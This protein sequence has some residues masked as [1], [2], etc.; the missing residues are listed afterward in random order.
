[1]PNPF[2]FS[3]YNLRYHSFDY[4]L[5]ETYGL[6]VMKVPLDAGFTCPNRDGTCGVGGCYFCSQEG[7][8]ELIRDK[9]ASLSQQYLTIKK[10]LNQKWPNA[11]TIPYFQAYTNTYAALAELKQSYEPFLALPEVVGLAIGT[12]PDCLDQ[13]II[14]YLVSLNQKTDIYLELGL[15][16]MFDTTALAFNRGYPLRVFEATIKRLAKTPLKVSVH[17]INGLPDETFDMM[18]DT[19]KYLSQLPLFG[20]KIH[21]LHLLSDSVYGQAYQTE[22]WPL[23]SQTEYIAL[24][25]KQLEL[26]PPELV[27]ER[28]TG[29]GVAA[30]LLAPLWTKKKGIVL[31]EIQKLLVKTDSYQGKYYQ[32]EK[33]P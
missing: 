1:M 32:K 24:V 16:T 21:M 23:M 18:I 3:H 14:D 30:K 5:K 27:I 7:S 26:L 31:N 15:Q 12:R 28:L 10:K 2:P 11:K 17:I 4:Y 33:R 29:D 20:I 22:A 9:T 13:P 25:V 19:A 8:G 6:K